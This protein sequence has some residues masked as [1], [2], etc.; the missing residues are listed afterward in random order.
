MKRVKHWM[1]G[2]LILAT[3]STGHAQDKTTISVSATPTIFKD[4]FVEVAKAF[5]AANPDVK[6]DLSINARQQDD[7]ITQTLR[8]ATTNNLPDVSLQGYNHL[9][10]LVDRKLLVPLDS[11][12]STEKNWK[13][14]GYAGGVTTTG[15]LQG[16][17]Y[18]LGVG[19]SVP[20]TYFNAD[21]VR[22]AGG[23]PAAFP[24]TWDGI[25]ELV[26]KIKAL[27]GNV[28]GGVFQYESTGNWTFQALINAQGGTMMNAGLT[29]MTFNGA[30]GIRAL[31]IM[32]RF[33]ELGQAE[34]AMSVDQARQLFMGGNVGI[35][36]DSSSSLAAFEKQAAGKFALQTA[37]L[38]LPSPH[39]VLPAAGIATVMFT[40]D[41]KRQAAAWR[42]MK[43]FSGPQAQTLV[44]R[45][46][47]YTPANTIVASDD[48]FLRG[49][50]EGNKNAA[51]ANSVVDRLGPWFS[52]PGPNGLKITTVIR[53]H[54]QSVITL[55]QKPEDAMK[56][57]TADVGALL[58]K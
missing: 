9:A 14:N 56:T 52:F 21:L 50:Y 30:E 35:L 51:A 17:V 28:S 20:I 48:R 26:Q 29:A 4:M 34:V 23:N 40:T 43:F 2:A 11:F 58:P 49:Y 31:E 54:L 46:T 6:I 41:K 10:T 13:D 57:M 19:T 37:P 55:R 33:G 15:T 32:R 22:K 38:P 27:G 53:D 39:G 24:K 1:A 44:G 42:F 7:Q 12:V 5:E 18:A 36:I 47:G 3:M 45:M 8:D 25:L 16:R